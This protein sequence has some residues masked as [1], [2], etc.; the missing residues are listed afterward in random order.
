MMKEAD[1]TLFADLAIPQV[2]ATDPLLPV[3]IMATI[4]FITMVCAFVYV[5]RHLRKIEKTLAADQLIPHRSG[6]AQQH[7]ADGL[8][9]PAD[10]YRTAAVSN[11]QHLTDCALLHETKMITA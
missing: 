6:R 11:H 2:L 5:L 4:A 3:R 1:V 10:R 8:S 9:Y 7:G